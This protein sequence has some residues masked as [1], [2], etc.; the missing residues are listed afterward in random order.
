MI[1]PDIKNA[2]VQTPGYGLKNLVAQ[3]QYCACSKLIK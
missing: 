2:E 3:I 1:K